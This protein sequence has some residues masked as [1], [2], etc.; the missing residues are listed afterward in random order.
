M[1]TKIIYVLTSKGRDEVEHKTSLLFGDMKR[2]LSMVDGLTNFVELSKRAAPSLRSV[3]AELVQELNAAGFIENQEQAHLTATI[4]VPPAAKLAAASAG[5]ELDFTTIMRVPSAQDMAAE[6]AKLAAKKSDAVAVQQDDLAK[7]RLQ[8]KTQAEDKLALEHKQRL[9]AMNAAKER[10]IA[11]QLKQQAEAVAQAEKAAKEKLA[12]EHRQ[13]EL[14]AKQAE[15]DARTQLEAEVAR[16]KAEQALTK[17]KQRADLDKQQAEIEARA[18]AKKLAQ[19]Q[20]ETARKVAEEAAKQQLEIAA[21]AKQAAESAKLKVE[22]ELLELKEQAERDKQQALIQARLQAEQRAAEQAEA[23]RVQ[24]AQIALQ[25]EALAARVKQEAEVAQRKAE[26]AAQ[27]AQ[28]KA[29]QELA[30]VKQEAELAKQEAEL[31]ARE[32]AEQLA[33]QQIEAA[34]IAAQQAAQQQIELAA[35]A[36]QEAELAKLKAQQEA[37]LAKQKA[38]EELAKV[39]QEAE[40]LKAKQESE[41]LKAKQEA[42]LLKAEQEAALLKAKQEAEMLKVKQAAELVKAQQNAIALQQQADAQAQLDKQRVLQAS[43][44]QAARAQAEQ[45]VL[46]AR[47]ELA[48][49]KREAEQL[50]QARLQADQARLE[51]EQQ[52][53]KAILAA[54]FLAQQ[55]FS[56]NA[57]NQQLVKQREEEE[58]RVK[59]HVLSSMSTQARNTPYDTRTADSVK[60]D[61][62]DLSAFN[63]P[64]PPKSETISATQQASDAAMLREVQQIAQPAN[65]EVAKPDEQAAAT[66]QAAETLAAQTKLSHALEAKRLAEVQAK[67]WNDAEQRATETAKAQAENPSPQ[68]LPPLAKATKSSVPRQRKPLA[69]QGLAATLLVLL[70]LAAWLLPMVLSGQEYV[71][72]IEAELS[73]TLQQ[74]VHISTLSARLLP[75]PQLVLNDVYIG[76][77]KQIKAQHVVLNFAV[78]NLFNDV[79]R[80]D[81]VELQSAE[82]NVSGVLEVG[83]WLEKIAESKRFP[84][85]NVMFEQAKLIAPTVQFDDLAGEMNFLP[86]GMFQ[87]AT[88]RANAGKYTLQVN[89]NKQAKLDAILN[90][91]SSALPLLPNWNFA[92]LTAK[93]EL[94]SRGFVVNDFDGRIAGGVLQGLAQLDW[95]AGWSLQGTLTAKNME[96]ANFNKLLTG[97]MQGSARFKLQAAELARLSD[98]AQLDGSFTAKKG[99][100]SGSDIVE[101]ARLRSKENLSGGRTHFDELSGNLNY[102][103]NAYHF[104]Q[105]K[106]KSGV[107]TANGSADISNRQMTGRMGASLSIQEGVGAV[108]L[109]LSGN[110]D[111]PIV[112]TAR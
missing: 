51:A 26:Q 89:V 32:Q 49:A 48:A 31:K 10:Q 75:S 110:T 105:I 18:L 103:N 14:T 65:V 59:Q 60:L 38:S 24:A 106:I 66:Q 102:A 15:L 79:K 8:E 104:K 93:G 23:A 78:M 83:P 4:K 69:W 42:L 98:S 57:A 43:M 82:L 27:A 39:R 70:V 67:A 7:Q 73:A 11:E 86:T 30:K 55:D 50:L 58:K 20:A 1:N 9:Q 21:Q 52:A 53:S 74:P 25:Q 90:V 64:P 85:S 2:A 3:F 87:S 81:V 16:F 17:A 22:Q 54:Q 5:S 112:H 109:Q 77:V 47:N 62:I 101:T 107:L 13:A 97:E 99:L 28:L 91:R 92:D 41:L 95:S 40:R 111:T 44:E 94:S 84:I 100:I 46:K 33:K 34:R 68:S 19:E 71:P 63:A 45:D 108:E 6:A 37:E 12:A 56:G 61:A 35:R 29:E 96:L 76:E 88:V 36:K 80:I 72:K